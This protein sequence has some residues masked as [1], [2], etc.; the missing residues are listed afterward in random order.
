MS[1]CFHHELA[2]LLSS[3]LKENEIYNELSLCLTC[4]HLEEKLKVQRLVKRKKKISVEAHLPLEGI[5]GLDYLKVYGDF[6]KPE[7]DFRVQK[8]SML[9]YNAELYVEQVLS[10]IKEL[11]IDLRYLEKSKTL[12]LHVSK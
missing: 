5:I 10:L 2:L 8:R 11:D 9:S 7:I 4:H 1:T 6:E 3:L 12:N